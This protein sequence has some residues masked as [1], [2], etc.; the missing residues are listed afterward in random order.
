MLGNVPKIKRSTAYG[1]LAEME[2]RGQGGKIIFPVNLG[3]P[4]RSE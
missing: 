2:A 4:S 3:I 1:Q